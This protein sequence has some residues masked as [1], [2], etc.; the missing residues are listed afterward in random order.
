MEEQRGASLV[1]V[2]AGPVGVAAAR[3]ALE[4]GV[5]SGVSAI[6]DPAARARADARQTFDAS[7]FVDVGDLGQGVGDVALVAF[8]SRASVV[9]PVIGQL[10]ELG[11]DVVTT[12]EELANPPERIRAGLSETCVQVGRSVVVTGANPGFVMDRLPVLLASGCRGVRSVR[13]ARRVDT[14][15]RREPLVRKSGYGLTRDEFDL[16][17][18]EGRIGHVGLEE[19]GLL[20]AEALGWSVSPVEYR[21]EPVEGVGGEVLGQHQVLVLAG[22]DRRVVLD[23][24]MAWAVDDPGDVIEVEGVSTLRTVVTGG[25]PGDE[26]TSARVVS[27]IRGLGSLSPGFYRPLDLPLTM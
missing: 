24:T 25:F 16:G 12:C 9:A 22:D 1:L 18:Q 5:V 2:G 6:V 26:G 7:E 21:I 3:S 11:F 15:T 17:V 20:V 4:E 19:S 13:V 27:A 8:S 14:R 23:L 10:L